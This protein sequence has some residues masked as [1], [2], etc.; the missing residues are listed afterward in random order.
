MEKQRDRILLI[1][2]W[3]HFVLALLLTPVLPNLPHMDAFSGVPLWQ[4]ALGGALLSG[5]ATLA[6]WLW[7]GQRIYRVVGGAALM[8]YSGL[9]IFISGGLT[10]MHF[11]VWIVLS[12][13]LIYYDW[14]PIVVASAVIAVHHIAG[15]VLFPHYLFE[16]G[17]SWSMVFTHAL[18]VVV[19]AAVLCFIAERI[20]RSTLAVDASARRVA[21]EQMPRL[22]SSITA[23]ANGDQTQ[24]VTFAVTRIADGSGDEIGMMA[25]SFNRLQDELEGTAIAVDAMRRHLR[26]LLTQVVTT[27]AQASES[28]RYLARSTEQIDSSSGQIARAIED[29]AR[30]AGEQSAST[31]EA[32][33]QMDDLA[34]AVSAV[35]TGAAAQRATVAEAGAAIASLRESLGHTAQR[36]DTVAHAAER[37]AHTARAGGVAVEQTI[38]SIGAVRDAVQRSSTQVEALGRSSAEIDQIVNAIAEIAEQTN[39]LALNAAIEAA[40]AG[41]HGK[42]FTV[43]AAE[44]RKLAER[45]SSEAREITTRIA[46][47]QQQ[48]ADVVAAMGAGSA[49]VEHSSTLGQQAAG[50]LESILGVVEE[51]SAQAHAITGAVAQMG[52]GVAAVGGVTDRV[53]AIA[54]QMAEASSTMQSSATQAGA[55]IDSIA[56]VSEQSAAGA[57]EV[58]ASTQEQTAGLQE[59]TAQVR[60]LAALANALQAATESFVLE[61]TAPAAR[62]RVRDSSTRVA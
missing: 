30:G 46:T 38:S 40:R 49:E 56:A 53:A 32:R 37:A 11:H 57:Q 60:E 39:L 7:A 2:L 42:G 36:V 62:A 43:V 6:Y 15:K 48:V 24:Q 35:S 26:D 47:I 33:S 19:E 14:L 41:E 25:Q 4:A 18:F 45:S 34:R 21:T 54:S 61:Q 44:V 52:D 9:L 58:S 23:M 5:T 12:F 10:A 50:A 51:T 59:M 28:A 3:G 16:M 55:A 13:L 31:G 1:V 17:T 8:G 22:R 20:R 27:A 29:V